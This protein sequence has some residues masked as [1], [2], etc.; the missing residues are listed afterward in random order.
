[1][2]GDIIF[3]ALLIFFWILYFTRD[4]WNPGGSDKTG[5]EKMIGALS[6]M[7][8]WPMMIFYFNICWHEVFQ[9][10]HNQEDIF[11]VSQ[12]AIGVAITVWII[13]RISKFS[14]KHTF[15]R[16]I[17]IAV[18][19]TFTSIYGP[20]YIPV[21]NWIEGIV[22]RRQEKTEPAKP[23]V[24]ERKEPDAPKPQIQIVYV[25][26]PVMKEIAV[27]EIEVD[28]LEPIIR[29]A[30]PGEWSELAY[31][32]DSYSDPVHPNIDFNV[33]YSGPVRARAHDAF[34]RGTAE[35]DL[36]SPDFNKKIGY[37]P[38]NWCLD[39]KSLTPNTEK[40]VIRRWVVRKQK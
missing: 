17:F 38:D 36:E 11:L 7:T 39:F 19:L 6:V 20:I 40:I 29:Y 14:W 1:M 2:I 13:F 32:K 35:A 28:S 8:L 12:I 18:I 9:T 5:T 33:S 30:K 24:L 25:E 3:L 23:V 27:K 37:S 31:I 16:A 21:K 10:Y 4:K 26:K 22:E 15:W 34:E